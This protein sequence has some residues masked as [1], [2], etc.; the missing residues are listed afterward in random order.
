MTSHLHSGI[1]QISGETVR[2]D[3]Y[4][5]IR[6]IKCVESKAE[7]AVERVKLLHSFE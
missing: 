7:H 3:D 1:K 5:E 6:Y 4:F 2:I